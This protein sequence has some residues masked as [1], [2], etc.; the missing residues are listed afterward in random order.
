MS[1]A[2]D[3]ATRLY[4]ALA[5]VDVDALA[6]LLHPEFTGHVSDGMPLAVG[7][8]VDGAEQMLVGVWGRVA[9]AYD[10]APQPAEYLEVAPDR[11]IVLGHYRGRSRETGTAFD[12][13]F[14]H[15]LRIADGRIRRLVQITDTR[16]WYDVLAPAPLD[17]SA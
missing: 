13:A 10:V 16:R 11:V 2:T 3:A 9:S 8:A 14:A 15:D 5:A 1:T 4:A 12:A 17:P 6:A 7:G